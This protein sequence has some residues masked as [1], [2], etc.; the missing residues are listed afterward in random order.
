ML[1]VGVRLLCSPARLYQTPSA[2]P[3]ELCVVCELVDVGAE[4]TNVE[5]IVTHFLKGGILPAQ[6]GVITPYEGQRA[7]VVTT[8]QRVGTL[9]QVGIF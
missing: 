3:L 4:A 2:N 1:H 7:H 6:I 8:M 5:K 9:R